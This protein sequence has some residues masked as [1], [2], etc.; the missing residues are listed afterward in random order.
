M[1][2]SW[3]LCKRSHNQHICNSAFFIYSSRVIFKNI[4]AQVHVF[5]NFDSKFRQNGWKKRLSKCFFKTG[6]NHEIYVQQFLQ[7]GLLGIHCLPN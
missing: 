2:D 4:I 6:L 3:L 7:V 1:G 5:A